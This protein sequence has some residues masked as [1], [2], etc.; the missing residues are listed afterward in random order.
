MS[1]H[2]VVQVGFNSLLIVLLFSFDFCLPQIEG[3][4]GE[5]WADVS[6]TSCTVFV[7]WKVQPSG[8]GK[9]GPNCESWR[10]LSTQNW[11]KS[12]LRKKY[13]IQ[14][15]QASLSILT[16]K[17]ST[18]TTSFSRFC[19]M[20]ILKYIFELIRHIFLHWERKCQCNQQNKAIC[21]GQQNIKI[22]L[23]MGREHVYNFVAMLPSR[24][25]PHPNHQACDQVIMNIVMIIIS[26]MMI[27]T[28]PSRS[29]YHHPCHDHC[30]HCP[31]DQ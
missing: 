13:Y 14:D 30:S 25:W 21:Y 3:P 24:D 10:Y 8:G 11:R 20:N 17:M 2:L 16:R 28:I 4:P 31:D 9:G 29:G 12:I 18:N 6:Y 5:N 26:I 7:T 22:N 19:S 15:W 1:R 27:I 23:E